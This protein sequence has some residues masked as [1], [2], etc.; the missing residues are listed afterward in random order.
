MNGT[1][2]MKPA[3]A[4][5]LKWL[6][7]LLNAKDYSTFPGNWRAVCDAMKKAFAELE[8]AGYEPGVLNVRLI[9]KNRNPVTHDD[10]QRLLPKLQEAPKVNDTKTVTVTDVQGN[11]TKQGPIAKTDGMFKKDDAFYKLRFAKTG[12]LWAHKLVMLMTPEQAKAAAEAGSTKRAAKFV[13]KGSPQT[14]GIREDMKLTYEDA[15]A[16]GALYNTCCECGR[17]LTN[18][19]SVYLGIG[20]KCGGREFGGEFKFMI[21]EAKLKVE[22]AK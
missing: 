9:A 1:T 10:F 18:E 2:T 8:D 7:D 11:V 12:K 4:K 20:P 13:F 19:L 5:Q 22:A 3:S 16:F 14:L 17:L 21:A 15:K 6:K